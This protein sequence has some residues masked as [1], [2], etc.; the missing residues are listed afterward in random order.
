MNRDARWFVYGQQGGILKQHRK[1]ARGR[2]GSRHLMHWRQAN[3][4][5]THGVAGGQAAVS[6]GSSLVDANFTAS[7]NA[8]DVRLGHALELA[9][10]KIIQALP[11][12]LLIHANN[13]CG[14]CRNPVD[15]G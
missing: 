4:R 3:G 11:M 1:T 8:I 13:A 12:R 15:N 14:L 2:R 7:D 6:L 10:Q 5:N 9:D